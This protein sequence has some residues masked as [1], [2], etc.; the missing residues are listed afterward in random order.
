[1]A[2]LYHTKLIKRDD[3][4]QIQIRVAFVERFQQSGWRVMGVSVCP[5][6]KRTFVSIIDT[7][8]SEFRRHKMGPERDA[9][10]MQRFLTV[11]TMD[12]M[13]AAQIELWQSMHPGNDV[14]A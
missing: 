1:M 2:S 10:V 11:V 7:D 4:T 14:G 3:G 13:R 8:S 12:E 5:P 9:Y 6:R